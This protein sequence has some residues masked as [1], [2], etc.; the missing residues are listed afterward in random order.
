MAFEMSFLLTIAFPESLIQSMLQDLD[1]LSR[2]SL[3]VF[4]D[5]FTFPLHSEMFVENY[6]FLSLI[7]TE[8]TFFRACLCESMRIVD[9]LLSSAFFS[10]SLVVCIRLLRSLFIQGQYFLETRIFLRGAYFSMIK[11]N[12]V[13]QS[14][15]SVLILSV[16]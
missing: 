2:T 15:T 6:C 1:L 16:C 12:K 9:F 3:I 11:A 4:Q 14:S 13:D 5:S 8:L 7:L 10:L